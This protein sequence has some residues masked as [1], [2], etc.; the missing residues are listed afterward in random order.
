MRN[1]LT[2]C[3]LAVFVIGSASTILADGGTPFGDRKPGGT[4]FGDRKA[5]STTTA[6]DG[7][8]P[9]GDRCGSCTPS[10]DSNSTGD[11]DSTTDYTDELLAFK[12]WLLSLLG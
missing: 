6:A 2:L 5:S 9:F 7:G 11:A 8:T 12:A 3:L 1:I 4:P 10:D